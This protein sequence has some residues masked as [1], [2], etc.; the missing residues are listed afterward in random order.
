MAE[1]DVMAETIAGLLMD[2]RRKVLEQ[3]QDTAALLQD[4]AVTIREYEEDRIYRRLCSQAIAKKEAGPD[5]K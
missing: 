4:A 5:G 2:M 3:A 1:T